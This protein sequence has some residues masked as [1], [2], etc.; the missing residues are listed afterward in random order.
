MLCNECCTGY[1][2]AGKS[3]L[4]IMRRKILGY[5]IVASVL[6][7]TYSCFVNPWGCNRFQRDSVS[8][9]RMKAKRVYAELERLKAGGL[10]LWPQAPGVLDADLES[11]RGGVNTSS[12]EYFEWLVKRA[13]SDAGNSRRSRGGMLISFVVLDDADAAITTNNVMWSIAEGVND[14][15]PDCVPV[16]VSENFDCSQLLLTYD[17]KASLPMVTSN[18]KP[19]VFVLKDGSVHSVESKY[20]NA[21]NVYKRRAFTGGPKSYLTPKGR[22]WTQK[23]RSAPVSQ[24]CGIKGQSL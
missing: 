16:L 10:D 19:V 2:M 9:A 6:L 23:P 20:L 21:W 7:L 3:Y 1:W 5:I 4:F 12:A 15:T 14:E 22:V 13:G 17:G 18:G 11:R 24:H 8:S